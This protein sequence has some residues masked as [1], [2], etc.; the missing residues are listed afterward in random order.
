MLLI[1]LP[2]ISALSEVEKGFKLNGNSFPFSLIRIL[3]AAHVRIA[4]FFSR[5]PD[6]SSNV[7]RMFLFAALL[8]SFPVHCC[9]SL[10]AFHLVSV[11]DIQ[12]IIKLILFWDSRSNQRT[13]ISD[14]IRD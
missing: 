4:K 11:L 1:D 7:C 9:K 3:F 12:Y 14:F 10:L 8:K 13:K 2:G 5:I 6:L